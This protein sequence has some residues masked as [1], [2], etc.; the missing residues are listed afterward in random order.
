[1]GMT[2]KALLIAGPTASGKSA[3]AADLAQHFGGMVINADSMQVYRD[4]RI[5][6]A[7]PRA[8]VEALVPHRLYGVLDATEI[9]SAARFVSLARQ[10][11]DEA[12]GQGLLPIIVG[13]TG[14]YLR[15]LSEGLAD[16]PPIPDD[17]RQAARLLMAHIGPARFHAEL[18][19][20]NPRAAQ[21]VRP[22]DA[23]RLVR[24]YEV[25]EATG[26][27]LID[28]HSQQQGADD[29]INWIRAA[30]L[31]ERGH[32]HQAINTRF[33]AM[34]RAGALDEA[35]AMAARNLDPTL[36]LSKVLGL[37]PLMAHLAGEMS[38]DMA[39]DR[40]QTDTRR[41][42][43]RQ[44]TWIRTQMIAWNVINEQDSKRISEEIGILLSK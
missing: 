37:R 23:Q 22:T 29:Q 33:Q 4:L 19:A 8:D 12:W 25:L 36:P 32:L 31:P 44:S 5:L 27:P 38:L 11:M 41:Y 42:A 26:R 7:R 35:A 43:K 1:M 13:G 20:R 3:V 39:I 10:A 18:S 16:I 2:M 40:G 30:I 15:A 17:T 9:C 6:T 21:G 28:W 14:L 24:A 34:V